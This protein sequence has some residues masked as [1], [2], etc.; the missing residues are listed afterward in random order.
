MD[1]FEL[2]NSSHKY[3]DILNPT[4]PEKIISVGNI[5][6]LNNNYRIIDFGCGTGEPLALWAENFG[7]FG[8]GIDISSKL[9]ER[10]RQNISQRGLGNCI[11][12]VHA[13]GSEYTSDFR[14]YDAATCIGATF[15]WGG[16]RQTIQALKTF[17]RPGAKLAIG[18]VYWL[19][20]GIPPEYHDTAGADIATFENELLQITMEEGYDIEYI[21]RSSLDDWDRYNSGRWHSLIRWI[22]E[23]PDHPDRQEIIDYLHHQQERY[24]KY[25]REYLG[26]AIYVLNP[27]SGKK[28]ESREV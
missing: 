9:C 28:E 21:V 6:G 3:L 8:T 2:M 20:A 22:D 5:L 1:F 18:E 17:V 27:M 10:A 24:L 26:W 12:I 19:K 11:E 16:Y 25:E 14:E 4:S 15:I 23:N 13:N 7:I